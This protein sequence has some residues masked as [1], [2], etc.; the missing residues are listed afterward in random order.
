MDKLKK[1][2][3]AAIAEETKC[4]EALAKATTARKAAENAIC[5]P[6][7]KI[8]EEEKAKKAKALADALA[9]IHAP[10]SK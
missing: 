8:S 2:L 9:E 5:D 3:A 1:D 7:E 6:N 10:K 4:L